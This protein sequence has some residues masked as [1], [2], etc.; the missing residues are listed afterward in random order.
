VEK[1]RGNWHGLE[2]FPLGT[3]G[4]ETEIFHVLSI[5]LI[6]LYSTTLVPLFC[7]DFTKY[8]FVESGKW[9]VSSNPSSKVL[10]MDNRKAIQRG[11]C[12]A[13]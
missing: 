5:L 4:R 1:P 2:S 3:V 8:N 11:G 9:K 10:G 7:I 6:I 12:L 13:S